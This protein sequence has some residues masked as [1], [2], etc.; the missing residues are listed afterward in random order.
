MDGGF[1]NKNEWNWGMSNTI[2]WLRGF[3]DKL[4]QPSLILGSHKGEGLSLVS[5]LYIFPIAHKLLNKLI[6]EWVLK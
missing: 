5:Q 1:C 2:P 4:H 3:A 6:N